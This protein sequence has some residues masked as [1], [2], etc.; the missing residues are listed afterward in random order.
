MAPYPREACN[1]TAFPH[2]LHLPLLPAHMPTSFTLDLPLVPD[3]CELQ[4][5][6]YY[7]L[8]LYDLA[9]AQVVMLQPTC[10]SLLLS[11]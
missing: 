10:L 1:S 9:Y 4:P 11:P 5:T 2:L 8:E 3:S 7:S 6:N